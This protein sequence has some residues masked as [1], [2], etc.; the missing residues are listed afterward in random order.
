MDQCKAA[1]HSEEDESEHQIRKGSC[2][3]GGHAVPRAQIPQE[4]DRHKAHGQ[5]GYGQHKKK[6]DKSGAGRRAQEHL[7]YPQTAERCKAQE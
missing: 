5:H 3:P 1:G 7:Q 2:T 6:K 4:R